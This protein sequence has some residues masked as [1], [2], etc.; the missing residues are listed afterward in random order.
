MNKLVDRIVKIGG[1]LVT[2]LNSSP[3]SNFQEL[4]S[5]YKIAYLRE[6]NSNILAI[7]KID[8]A[9]ESVYGSKNWKICGLVTEEQRKLAAGP[10]EDYVRDY[11]EAYPRKIF[12]AFSLPEEIKVSMKW[13]LRA[14]Q[15]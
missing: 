4:P 12:I 13:F 6:L 5:N 3:S 10:L 9:K 14:S 1:I 8:R 2:T 11:L 15:Q 7:R